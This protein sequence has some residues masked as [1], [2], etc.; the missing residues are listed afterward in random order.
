MIGGVGR[1]HQA[2]GDEAAAVRLS[3]HR[4]VTVVRGL[5][6]F[7]GGDE[8]RSLGKRVAILR[9]LV[10]GRLGGQ[11]PGEP[12]G[13]QVRGAIQRQPGPAAAACSLNRPPDE[14][15]VG[16]DD[17]VTSD[18]DRDTAG[19]EYMGVCPVAVLQQ[20][21]LKPRGCDGG[22]PVPMA[23]RRHALHG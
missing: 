21:V 12:L 3:P 16:A 18:R 13:G 11:L 2:T 8:R 9:G 17:H 14:L 23:D 6:P 1:V 19:G 4:P 22:L 5:D 7:G 15:A 10:R 20:C